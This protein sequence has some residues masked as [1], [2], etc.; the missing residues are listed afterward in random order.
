MCYESE[1][2][3]RKKWGYGKKNRSLPNGKLRK[4]LTIAT[5]YLVG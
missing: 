4:G 3:V 1:A 5:N 2:K